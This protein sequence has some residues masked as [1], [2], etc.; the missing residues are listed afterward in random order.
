MIP[1]MSISFK[2]TVK[3]DGGKIYKK[4]KNLGFNVHIGLQVSL[5]LFPKLEIPNDIF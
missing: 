1:E 5:S 3:L 2:K 4:E